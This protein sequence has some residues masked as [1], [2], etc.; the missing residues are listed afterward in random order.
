MR[1][2]D[3]YISSIAYGVPGAVVKQVWFILEIVK[4]KSQRFSAI[5]LHGI[6]K[7]GKC[8]LKLLGS[9][10]WHLLHFQNLTNQCEYG[11]LAT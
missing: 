1:R 8:S 3:H 2:L 11:K 6:N 7:F 5:S 4:L 10:N 9:A